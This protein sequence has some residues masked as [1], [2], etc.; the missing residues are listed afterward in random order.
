MQSVTVT[1]TVAIFD[2]NKIT[3]LCNGTSNKTKR[4]IVSSINIV[5]LKLSG[6]NICLMEKL[7]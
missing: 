2:K 5:E 7:I 4:G 3:N 6:Q 1:E